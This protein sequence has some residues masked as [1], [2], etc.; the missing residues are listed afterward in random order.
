MR[1]RGYFPNSPRI[2]RRISSGCSKK[3][4]TTL[5]YF[6]T[7]YWRSFC[8]YAD[9]FKRKAG[10]A[11]SLK[12]K[13]RIMQPIS[14]LYKHLTADFLSATLKLLIVTNNRWVHGLNIVILQNECCY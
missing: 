11:V 8:Y 5:R 10:E 1:E 7:P 12:E 3:R 9:Y 4:I 14:D 6:R 2:F 13:C